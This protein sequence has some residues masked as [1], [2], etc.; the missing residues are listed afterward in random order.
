MLFIRR[1]FTFTLLIFVLLIMLSC[2]K[3]YN[4]SITCLPLLWSWFLI[5]TFMSKE[6]R[7][8]FWSLPFDWVLLFILFWFVL[9]PIFFVNVC[10][11]RFISPFLP[12]A[13]GQRSTVTSSACYFWPILSLCLPLLDSR[14]SSF[15][16]FYFTWE[17]VSKIHE[18]CGTTEVH[19]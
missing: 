17:S 10:V 14:F 11:K 16:I 19:S 12:Y 1:A 9:P 5:S 18:K 7:C 8:I 3:F 13:I 15:T 4:L 6:M 2:S